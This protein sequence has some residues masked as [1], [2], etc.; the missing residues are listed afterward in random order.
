M[1]APQPGH[2]R[3]RDSNREGVS[4]VFVGDDSV[5]MW[6]WRLRVFEDLGCIL[7]K[8]WTV[9]PYDAGA[10]HKN[11]G[12]STLLVRVIALNRTDAIQYGRFASEVW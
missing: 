8:G 6:S 9:P 12:T 10:G 1:N 3:G 11:N 5:S 2:D 7:S 4:D